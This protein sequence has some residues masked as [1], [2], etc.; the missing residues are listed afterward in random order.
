MKLFIITTIIFVN[1]FN[2][3]ICSAGVYYEPSKTLKSN[4]KSVKQ[5]DSCNCKCPL[6]TFSHCPISPKSYT[7]LPPE[8]FPTYNNLNRSEGSFPNEYAHSIIIRGIIVDKNCIPVS[9]ANIA[10]W[11]D[12]E[13]GDK[14]YTHGITSPYQVNQ[15]NYKMCRNIKGIGKTY[16]TNEGRFMFITV[17]PE[18]MIKSRRKY[19]NIEINHPNFPKFYGK[20]QLLPKNT[21]SSKHKNYF[22][23]AHLNQDATSCY[24]K[25]IYDFNIV[26]NNANK[27]RRY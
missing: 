26:L 5:N 24:G 18:E 20:I 15:L 12:D 23:P 9:D 2:Y 11:Q 17:P 14:R 3:N 6:C 1:I 27:Y 21:N 25:A 7:D 4:K 19:I 22:I 13:Y 10:I 16:S 8:T